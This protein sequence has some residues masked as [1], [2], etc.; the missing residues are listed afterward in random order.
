MT[1]A[2]LA[3][4]LRERLTYDPAVGALYR[5]HAPGLPEGQ[6]VGSAPPGGKRQAEFAKKRYQVDALVWLLETGALPGGPLL[7]LDGDDQNDRFSNLQI[8]RKQPPKATAERLA[9]VFLVKA[10]AKFGNAHD[11]SRVVYRGCDAKVKIGC[12]AHGDFERS[13]T[14][15]L[16]SAHGCPACCTER[17]VAASRKTPEERR[18]TR[19]AY[20]SRRRDLYTKAGRRHYRKTQ[21]SPMHQAARTCRNLLHRAIAAARTEKDGNTEAVLGYTVAEFK[22]HIEQQ[23]EPWMSWSN[24]GEWHVDHKQPIAKLVRDGVTD[25]RIINALS[26]LRPLSKFENLSKKDRIETE[27]TVISMT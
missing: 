11:M 18:A 27:Y 16:M 9:A 12:S 19:L 15:Y 23:F 13:P 22:A 21:R 17:A 26:N 10:Y 5:K 20:V 6:R 24:H 2:E 3:A 14:E 8:G 1:D 25:P 7:H 4:L